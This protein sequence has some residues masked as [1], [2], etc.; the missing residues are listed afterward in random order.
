MFPLGARAGLELRMARAITMQAIDPSLANA[1]MK[2]SF[3]GN[4]VIK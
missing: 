3:F 2:M 4:A 1:Q